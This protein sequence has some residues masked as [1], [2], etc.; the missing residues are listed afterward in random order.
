MGG[1]A[2]APKAPDYTQ[3]AQAQGQAN[4]QA[5]L[6]NAGLTTPNVNSPF[7]NIQ[8]DRGKP[9]GPNGTYLPG[10]FTLNTKLSPGQQYLLDARTRGLRD[11]S[12]ELPGVGDYAQSFLGRGPNYSGLP[13]V[14]D[15]AE[16]LRN[17]Q[18]EAL[19]G[20]ATRYMDDRFGRQEDALRTRLMNQGI[21]SGGE[22][23]NN[24]LKEFNRGREEAYANA[25][26]Q[27]IIGGGQEAQRVFGQ[28]LAARQQGLQEQ[29][30]EQ[31]DAMGD[32]SWLLNQI[33]PVLP[34]QMQGGQ[35]GA[36]AAPIFDATNQQ[37]NAALN[38]ANQ[39]NQAS[40]STW[41]QIG[42]LG[43]TGAILY[44]LGA[45]SDRRLKQE[46]RRIGTTEE[47]RLPLYSFRYIFAPEKLE[48]GVMADEVAEVLPEAVFE[49]PY[50]FKMVNY[51]L[52]R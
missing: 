10:D 49:G 45:F 33:N 39:Q 22:A 26:D 48:I 28:N 15:G 14:Q 3:A 46:I 7:G 41:G 35:G 1:K 13:G 52:I 31:A 43:S 8:W 2:K 25:Q 27:A 38:R 24:E 32:Y 4:I 16:N 5:A 40:S 37:Y 34:T 47:L 9:S 29:G 19:Y 11:L 36:Q 12:K 6:V 42:Q 21:Y 44:A 17:R 51:A 50:G 23:Y 20:R 18:E 30:A